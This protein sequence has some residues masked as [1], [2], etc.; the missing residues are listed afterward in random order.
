MNKSTCQSSFKCLPQFTLQ[1]V[2]RV[3]VVSEDHSIAVNVCHF[4]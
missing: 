1:C 2:G 3:K 4:R